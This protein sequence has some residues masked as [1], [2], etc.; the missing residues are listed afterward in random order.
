MNLRSKLKHM[1]WKRTLIICLLILLVAG[2]VVFWIFN[3]EPEARRQGATKK[4]AMLVDVVPVQMGGHHPTIVATGTVRPARRVQLSPR[5]GGYVLDIAQD[6][7]PGGFVKEGQMLLQLDPAD[8]E[9]R[10][11]LRKS[12]LA[13]VQADLRI[14]QGNQNVARQD[15][16]LLGDTL[17][18]EREALVLRQPQLEAVRAQIK[19]AESAVTQA[20]LNL[21]RAVIRAPFDAQLITRNTNIGAQ[22]GPGDS[23]GQLVGTDTY[24]VTATVPTSQLRWLRFPKQS[25]KEGAPVRLVSQT[26]WPEGAYRTGYLYKLLGTLESNTRMARV[27]IAVP[28][29]LALRTENAG[30]PRLMVGAFVEAHLPG[31]Q[32]G[33]VVRLDRD[34]LREDETVWVMQGDTLD[35]RNVKLALKDAKY[36][37][38]RSGLQTGDKVVKTNLSTVVEGAA[39]RLPENEP[40]DSTVTSMRSNTLNTEQ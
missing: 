14:E 20:E 15:Y 34:L 12:E 31:E 1:N 25:W 21:E 35:I 19:A 18:P 11:T 30:K 5:V 33:Q 24:W 8:Y 7:V 9:N 2:G 28:D 37:Y 17:A 13:Q 6:F 27:V 36:A 4:T 26:A 39:L 40:S 16:Q 32:L 22:V 38:I 3:T 29:P 10:L 23:L